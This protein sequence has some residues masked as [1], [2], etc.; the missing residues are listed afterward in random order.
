MNPG[1]GLESQNNSL[2]S[3]PL[4]VG[5]IEPVLSNSCL[6]PGAPVPV[7]PS[8]SIPFLIR[9]SLFPAA[10]CSRAQGRV[11]CY[12]IASCTASDLQTR[13]TASRHPK[14]CSYSRPCQYHPQPF[15]PRPP[16]P[17]SSSVPW[18]PQKP[19]DLLPESSYTHS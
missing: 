8:K 13:Q 14:P 4:S 16:F 3:K 7:I 5:G 17:S 11:D 19:F 9:S 2:S 15:P 12:T 18:P 6:R 10:K 1:E